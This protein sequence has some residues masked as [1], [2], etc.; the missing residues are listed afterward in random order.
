MTAIKML[1]TP[2]A[3]SSHSA[4]SSTN[5]QN[6]AISTSIGLISSATTSA[7][8]P[9]PVQVQ[10]MVSSSTATTPKGLLILKNEQSRQSPTSLTSTKDTPTP[11][12]GGSSFLS[13]L[14]VTPTTDIKA[15]VTKITETLKVKF[16]F[17][18]KK[19]L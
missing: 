5:T 2:V 6:I 4:V 18:L 16:P 14:L 3:V 11:S 8:G 19:M 10:N 12:T 9:T 7:H 13:S 17:F 15:Q 1:Q